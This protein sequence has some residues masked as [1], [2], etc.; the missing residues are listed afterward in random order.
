M[1]RYSTV[2]AEDGT[3]SDLDSGV[4]VVD[5]NKRQPN[6]LPAPREVPTIVVQEAESDKSNSLSD[7]YEP[8]SPTSEETLDTT[9]SPLEDPKY[10][11][12]MVRRGRIFA[13]RHQRRLVAKNGDSN[14]S[15]TKVSTL[16][17]KYL[18]DLFTTLIDMRWRYNLL[19]FFL[20][21]VGTWV[22]FALLWWGI[23]LLHKDHLHKDD[24]DWQPCMGNVF[25]F[26][27]ALLFSLETQHTIGYGYRVMEPKC[28]EAIILLMC[29]SCVG[30]FIQSLMTGLIFAKLSRPKRRRQTIMFSKNAVICQR[31]GDLCLLFRVGDMRKSHIVGTSIR[32]LIVRNRLTKEGEQLPVCQENI[33]LETEARLPDNYVFMGWPVTVMHKINNESPLW[34]I[35]A[36]Q[37]LRERLEIVVILEG[38]VESTGMTTQVRTSYLPSEI[39]WGHRLTPLVT[40]QKENGQYKIDYSEFDKTIPIT[41]PECSAKELSKREIDADGNS[42]YLSAEYPLTFTASWV[43]SQKPQRT[44]IPLRKRF[45]RKSSK[46]PELPTINGQTNALNGLSTAL[47]GFARDSESS[48]R[49]L[50]GMQ[51]TTI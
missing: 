43:T 35:S 1:R 26:T 32:A 13:E 14:I 37:L 3:H 20:A 12:P 44:P 9:I 25:D 30:V 27:T 33:E 8:Q 45:F 18:L 17:R 46:Q 21:F 40:Y 15:N 50:H 16:K 51:D 7:S 39:F 38:T 4:I 2:P 36:E 5:T 6:G 11:D 24:E 42:Q 41:M 23:C 34:D 29:Q 22:G 10:M 19:M 49:G 28:T 47:D 48:M 31:D